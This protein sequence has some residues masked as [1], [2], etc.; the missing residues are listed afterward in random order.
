MEKTKQT[1]E[2][3]KLIN[4]Y[5]LEKRNLDSHLKI[6]EYF[7]EILKDPTKNTLNCSPSEFKGF[8]HHLK[9]HNVRNIFKRSKVKYKPLNRLQFLCEHLEIPMY[10]FLKIFGLFNC[11]HPDFDMSKKHKDKEKNIEILFK[12]KS[13][14]YNDI[15][16]FICDSISKNEAWTNRFE[17]VDFDYKTIEFIVSKIKKPGTGIPGSNLDKSITIIWAICILYKIPFYQMLNHLDV[18][19]KYDNY[20]N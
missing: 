11:K 8:L 18:L 20:N 19:S 7:D 15:Y 16:G 13:S 5:A 10:E 4:K 17:K 14:L 9:W 3:N 6:L 1:T 2:I 12:S